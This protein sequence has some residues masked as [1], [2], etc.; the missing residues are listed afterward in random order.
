M[1]TPCCVYVRDVC[2][3]RHLDGGNILLKCLLESLFQREGGVFKNIL[4]EEMTYEGSILSGN[5]LLP[6]I[7]SF[8]R[9]LL[10]ILGHI[11][12]KYPS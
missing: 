7:H 11:L 4:P 8:K 3:K 12:L 9:G 2:P 1:N 10:P 6:Q 5:M